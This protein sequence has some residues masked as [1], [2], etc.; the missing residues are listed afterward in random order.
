MSDD[1]KSTGKEA[2]VAISLT[3]LEFSW[4]IERNHENPVRTARVLVKI[5]TST[6]QI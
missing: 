6:Y 1:L 5:P 4:G 3:D 2:V